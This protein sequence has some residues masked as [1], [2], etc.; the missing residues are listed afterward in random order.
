[1]SPPATT[2]LNTTGMP[3]LRLGRTLIIF[4]VSVAVLLCLAVV[5]YAKYW[6]FSREAVLEDLKEATDS[7]VTAQSYHPTYFPPGCVLYGLEFRHGSNQFKLIEIQKLRV[8]GSYLGMLR[9]HVPRIVADGAHVFI[10]PFG[11]KETF[12]T[13]HSGTAVDELVAN[14]AFVEFE[15]RKP[16]EHPFRFDVHEATF[17]DL[18]WGNAITYHLKFR[19]P[20][21]PGEISADGKFGPWLTGQSGDT[22]FSG[23]YTFERADLGVYG[24]IKGMLA[25]QGHFDGSLKRI[26]VAGTTDTPDFQVKSSNNKFHLTTRFDAYVNAENGDTFLNSVEAHFAGTTVVA[27]GSIAKNEPQKG[28]FTRIQLS[29]RRGRIEDILGLF[30]SERAPMSG[31]TAL[32]ATAEIPPGDEPFLKKVKLEGT[33]GIGHG[34]FTKPETQKDVNELS[35]GARGQNKED[36]ATVLTDLKGSVRLVEGLTHFSDISFG[37]P[38]AKAQMHGTY[39]ILEPH[40]I[41]L[42]GQMRVE[43]KISKTTSGVK[44]FFLKIMDPIFKKRKKGE[45]VPVHIL[46]T[47]EKPNFG[48]DLAQKQNA[49][50]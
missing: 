41:D 14:G 2:A 42:H 31:E 24:R 5:F 21:P 32:N 37:I 45:V 50:K 18:L 13:K 17:R 49:K 40:R 8:Q 1:M 23:T 29:A 25:S 46:G 9:R 30:T 48:L 26:N 47:Y 43:S 15:P 3:K 44:S 10:P 33:F 11:T 35:A 7:A 16:H 27:Q 19:N 20:N 39:S 34:S 28:K 22:P 38:G 4:V 36:P 6:P 12:N